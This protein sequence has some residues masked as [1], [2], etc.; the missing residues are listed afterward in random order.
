MQMY[1]TSLYRGPS[2][3]LCWPGEERVA[4]SQ[5]ITFTT[6]CEAGAGGRVSYCAY[7][8]SFFMSFI[9]FISTGVLLIFLLSLRYPTPAFLVPF[10]SL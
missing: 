2:T 3:S 9:S 1:V 8:F 4:M 10:N 5:N 6:W 7:L